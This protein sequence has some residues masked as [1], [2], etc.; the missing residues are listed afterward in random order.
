MD[1]SPQT[2]DSPMDFSPQTLDS[3]M[4]FSPQAAIVLPEIA[5]IRPNLRSL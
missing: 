4:D 3:P 5:D 2:L 1:F